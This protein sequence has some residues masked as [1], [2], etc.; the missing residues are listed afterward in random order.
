MANRMNER[1]IKDLIQCLQ[2]HF[3]GDTVIKDLSMNLFAAP[4]DK[5]DV[6]SDRPAGT[7]SLDKEFHMFAFNSSDKK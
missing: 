4:T 7:L 2:M 3:V 6:G 5:D 1:T